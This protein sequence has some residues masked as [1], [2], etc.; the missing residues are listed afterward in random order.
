MAKM[1][2]RRPWSEFRASG[3][4][5]WVNRSLHLFGWAIVVQMNQ[6]GEITNCWPAR[7]RFRGFVEG[8]EEEGFRKLTNHIRSNIDRTHREVD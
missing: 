4:L 2:E 6:S 7:V 3:L 1:V 8:D 5:W